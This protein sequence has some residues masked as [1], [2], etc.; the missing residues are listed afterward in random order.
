[1]GFWV[2]EPLVPYDWH[3]DSDNNDD[4]DWDPIMEALITI[5]DTRACLERTEEPVWGVTMVEWN[6]TTIPT[7]VLI[8]RIIINEGHE[9]A[10]P[11]AN[12]HR[13]GM[14]FGR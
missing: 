14:I 4:D 7:L 2:K 12:R 1:M 3:D 13:P 11:R 8:L 5:N 10:K 6:P 9:I